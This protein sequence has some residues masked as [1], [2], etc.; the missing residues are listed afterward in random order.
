MVNFRPEKQYGFGFLALFSRA[1]S[2]A[3]LRSKEIN[4]LKQ[5]IREA[6][7]AA[8]RFALLVETGAL[9]SLQA[10]YARVFSAR[11]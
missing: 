2:T 7:A 4:F 10:A 6:G 11:F 9:T 3:E 8:G 5:R 1:A